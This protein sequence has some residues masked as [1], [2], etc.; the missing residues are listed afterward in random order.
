MKNTSPTFATRLKPGSEAGGNIVS[1]H[2]GMYPKTDGLNDIKNAM[3]RQLYP[4]IIPASISP[5]TMGCLTNSNNFPNTREKMRIITTCT[6]NTLN[7][8]SNG[9]NNLP[10]AV[11]II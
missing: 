11:T 10:F 8:V 7:G 5:I 6:K 1:L 3:N 4:K 9:S 2:P